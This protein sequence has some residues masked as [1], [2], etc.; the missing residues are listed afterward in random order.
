M[1]DE[2]SAKVAKIWGVLRVIDYVPFFLADDF[3]WSFDPAE[4]MRLNFEVSRK[5][6]R[7]NGG[8]TVNFLQME[9]AASGALKL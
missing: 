6:A 5:V 3:T 9:R 2:I 7:S 1:A 4:A 8:L